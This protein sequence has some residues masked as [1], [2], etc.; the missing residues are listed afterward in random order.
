DNTANRGEYF[1]HRWFLRFG[2]LRH[3]APLLTHKA[4]P[5]GANLLLLHFAESR[6]RHPCN[7][8]ASVGI[9]QADGERRHQ[10]KPPNIRGCL[11]SGRPE[12]ERRSSRP[13]P[14][15]SA[16]ADHTPCHSD[17]IAASTVRRPPPA[18]SKKQR[19]D[20][21]AQSPE[22]RARSLVPAAH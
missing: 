2:R 13:G 10:K 11:P 3:A 20:R 8:A 12:F 14:A 1:L 18:A 19:R 16:P 9:A 21:V 6:N 15:D 5:R 4:A 22:P 17:P 7:V